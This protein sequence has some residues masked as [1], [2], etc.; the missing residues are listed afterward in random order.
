ME[1]KHL[2]LKLQEYKLHQLHIYELTILNSTSFQL[3]EE[4]T[5]LHTLQNELQQQPLG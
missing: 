1:S 5:V 2:E 4:C 3:D